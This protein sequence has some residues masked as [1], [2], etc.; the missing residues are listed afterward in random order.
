MTEIFCFFLAK[1]Y[2][3][4]FICMLMIWP[5]LVSSIVDE[6]TFSGCIPSADASP[7]CG[8]GFFIP[9]FLHIN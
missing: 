8:E 5:K 3:F 4:V 7:Y 9:T 2:L 1:Q 6:N